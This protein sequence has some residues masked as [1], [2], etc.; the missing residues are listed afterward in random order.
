M[1]Q[2]IAY[3]TAP[4]IKARLTQEIIPKLKNNAPE[5]ER[6]DL[7]CWNFGDNEMPALAEAIIENTS[8]KVLQIG[9]NWIVRGE[10][11]FRIL[12]ENQSLEVVSIGGNDGAAHINWTQLNNILI[13]QDRCVEVY[14][15]QQWQVLGDRSTLE[16]HQYHNDYAL[17]LFG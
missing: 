9:E 11:L 16:N 15:G 3:N 5:M 7:S 6:L 2:E 13:G 17:A 10:E 1:A 8:M 4:H 12:A 14:D